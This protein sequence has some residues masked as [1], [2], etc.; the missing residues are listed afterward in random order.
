MPFDLISADRYGRRLTYWICAGA[1]I[2][3][4]IVCIFAPNIGVLMAFRAVQGAAVTGYMTTGNAV[5]ADIFP[6]DQRGRA[7]GKCAII[8][9]LE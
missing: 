2:A 8:G 9:I 4:T 3:S 6:P 5:V 7:S 1:F